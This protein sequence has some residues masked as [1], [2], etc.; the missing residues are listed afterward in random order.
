M[1]DHPV[2]SLDEWLAARRRLLD[3]EKEFTRLRDEL[4]RKRRA[5]PWLRID[6]DYRFDG[7]EGPNLLS[8]ICSADAGS[9]SSIT[10]CS[11]P[12][13]RSPARAAPSGPTAITASPSIWR[14][15]TRG[16]SPSLPELGRMADKL[17]LVPEK[18]QHS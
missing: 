15:A 11:G 12:T 14:P 1:T 5:I 8:A 4:S 9:S 7:P 18:P 6:K 3:E 10:S 13:G 2:V 17:R 16:S